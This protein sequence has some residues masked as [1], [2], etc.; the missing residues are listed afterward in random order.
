MFTQIILQ[1]IYIVLYAVFT[2]AETAVISIND[3]LLEKLAASGGK[4]AIQLKKVIESP[5][6][7]LSSVHTAISFIG[8]L[9]SAFAAV[10]FSE[11]LAGLFGNV[12]SGISGTALLYIS[13]IIITIAALFLTIV[14]GELVPKRLAKIPKKRH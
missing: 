11:K 7:F 6:G 3:T 12:I 4:K 8:F 9:G 13:A 1:I 2:C 5:S 10:N 14:F